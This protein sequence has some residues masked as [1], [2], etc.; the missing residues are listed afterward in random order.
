MYMY[1]YTCVY[2]IYIISIAK[3]LSLS[4]ESFEWLTREQT[5]VL[6]YLVSG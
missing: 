6:V 2:V 5:Y 3:R 4:A 1:M